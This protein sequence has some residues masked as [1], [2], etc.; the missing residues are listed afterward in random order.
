MRPFLD[1]SRFQAMASRNAFRL[2]KDLGKLWEQDHSENLTLIPGAGG[3]SESPIHRENI[4]GGI[5]GIFSLAT[6]T[7]RLQANRPWTH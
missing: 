3:Y 6:A 5:R 4:R 1:N 7:K 2:D